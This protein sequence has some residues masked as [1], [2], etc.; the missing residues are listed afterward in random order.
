[1]RERFDL[2]AGALAQ[3]LT[4]DEAL[5]CA[6]I[7]RRP[8]DLPAGY[9]VYLLVDPVTDLAFY[10]GKGKGDRALDHARAERGGYEGNFA[11]A[12]RLRAIRMDGRTVAIAIVA[13]GLQEFDAFAIERKVIE[14]CRDR[15]TNIS[16]AS[17]ASSR[18]SGIA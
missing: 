10:V 14:A 16:P 8:F 7:P 15:L 11:K 3:G 4:V 17:A 13:D 9:Y 18:S 12:S 2:L 5:L 1:M 6:D